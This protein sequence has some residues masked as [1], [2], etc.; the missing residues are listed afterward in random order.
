M[1][2]KSTACIVHQLIETQSKR[3]RQHSSGIAENH[4]LDKPSEDHHDNTNSRLLTKRELADMTWGVRQLSKKLASIQ[5]KPRVKTV[6]LLTKAHDASLIANTRAVTE[7]L[8]SNDRDTPYVV[9]EYS[10]F[11]K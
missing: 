10:P 11:F 6:F 7:W 3:R 8:L 5:T 2:R 4:T 9:C 1:T